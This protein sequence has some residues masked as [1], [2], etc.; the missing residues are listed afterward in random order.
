MGSFD[1]A[2][3]WACFTPDQARLEKLLEETGDGELEP[4]SA[5]ADSQGETFIDHDFFYLEMLDER[6]L[7]EVLTI[8]GVD[9]AGARDLREAWNTK[10]P[11]GANALIFGEEADFQSPRDAD[12]DGV[13]I[14]YLGLF[15]HWA[16]QPGG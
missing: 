1:R 11:P 16:S 10:H 3:V 15:Q 8:L 4:I 6:P 12:Q 5:F 14:R 9:E 2:H 13:I 7:P